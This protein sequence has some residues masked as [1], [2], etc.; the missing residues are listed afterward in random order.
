MKKGLGDDPVKAIEWYRS[1]QQ[2]EKEEE[3][4][5]FQ[6]EQD[7]EEQGVQIRDTNFEA[8]KQFTGDALSSDDLAARAA[9]HKEVEA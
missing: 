1:Q 2:K 8:P 3:K 4:V 5:R 6:E 9:A 7:R